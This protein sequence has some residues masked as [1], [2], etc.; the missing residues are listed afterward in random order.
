VVITVSDIGIGIMP[1]KLDDI[2]KRFVQVDKSFTR[3]HEGSGIGLS[4]V[5][6]LVVMHGGNIAVESEYGR[7]S[8]FIV[9]LPTKRAQNNPLNENVKIM[10]FVDMHDEQIS[11][12]F[13]D[14]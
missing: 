5:K 3:N 2:F 8:K 4:L 12:E 11:I 10:K 13:S 14:I 9:T 6:E 1:D 7:G